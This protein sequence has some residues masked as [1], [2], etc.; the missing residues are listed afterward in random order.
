M[1][2]ISN[3]NL[4]KVNRGD[5]FEFP[6]L[7][8][9]GSGIS[10]DIY[11]LT[12]VDEV[13]LS[14]CEPNQSFQEGIIRKIAYKE[15]Q[16]ED[17]YVKFT[18]IDADTLNLL[19]G[20]YYYEVKLIKNGALNVRHKSLDYIEYPS[21]STEREIIVT[22]A[23]LD[24]FSCDCDPFITI[25][26]DEGSTENI[27]N[28]KDAKI[29]NS[30]LNEIN[31]LSNN[32]Q[33]FLNN[34]TLGSE[35]LEWKLIPN[36]DLFNS[37]LNIFNS[38]K[39]LFL[40]ANISCLQNTT[41]TIKTSALIGITKPFII[42]QNT[43]NYLEADYQTVIANILGYDDVQTFTTYINSLINV[44]LSSINSYDTNPLKF[45][46]TICT[47]NNSFVLPYVFKNSLVPEGV[48]TLIVVDSTGLM[49]FWVDNVN[50]LFKSANFNNVLDLLVPTSLQIYGRCTL[51]EILGTYK[52]ETICSKRKFILMD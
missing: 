23:K 25:L 11:Y 10:P 35:F 26:L 32:F 9:V 5:F 42:S 34:F 43:Y 51:F 14:I 40:Q 50:E 29:S 21:C 3:N 22:S 2:I 4:I 39:S 33:L 31:N 12:D 7:L 19:P 13:F 36:S 27:S 1:G 24:I 47:D 8:N 45:D 17:G 38:C 41:A 49:Y 44:F 18:F 37:Y 28:H 52:V 16:D 15:D 6:I 48:S 20:T 46:G 30:L